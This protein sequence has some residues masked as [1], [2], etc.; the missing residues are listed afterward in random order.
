MVSGERINVYSDSRLKEDRGGHKRLVNTSP[1]WPAH[2]AIQFGNYS[3]RHRFHLD[4]AM[5]N[6]NLRIDSGQKIDVIGRTGMYMFVWFQ[7]HPVYF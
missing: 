5:K 4:Y 3:L 1:T 2:G 7:T 6:I